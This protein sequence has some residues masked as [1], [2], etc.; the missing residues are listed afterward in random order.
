MMEMHIF[1]FSF[2]PPNRS[3]KEWQLCTTE[4]PT[5]VFKRFGGKG[6]KCEPCKA[7]NLCP[8]SGLGRGAGVGGGG[9]GGQLPPNFLSQWDGYACAPPLKFGI[10]GVSLDTRRDTRRINT[11]APQEKI[12]P[13]PLGLGT[14]CTIE[15][16]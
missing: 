15:T 5:P 2:F 12:V 11:F 1:L 14:I 8:Q 13:A 9:Q 3:D 10:L 16:K 7:Q 4:G 6:S